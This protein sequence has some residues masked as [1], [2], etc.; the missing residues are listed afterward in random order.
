[1]TTKMEC[2]HAEW[3]EMSTVPGVPAWE[4]PRC[5]HLG[6]CSVVQ[7]VSPHGF[8]GEHSVAIDYVEYPHGYYGPG[9]PIVESAWVFKG[10]ATEVES[11]WQRL[12]AKM[13]AGEPPDPEASF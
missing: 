4:I 8:H 9:E 11:E 13:M 7:L 12:H 5:A 10:N 6:N 2:F 1:M 3:K